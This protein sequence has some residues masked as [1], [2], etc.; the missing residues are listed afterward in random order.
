MRFKNIV[1]QNQADFNKCCRLKMPPSFILCIIAL[2]FS[3]L[4]AEKP[5]FRFTHLT[6]NDGLSQSNVTCI[7]QDSSGFMWFGTFNGLNRFDGY[8]FKTYHYSDNVDY[9][10]SHNF[11]SDLAVDKNGLIWIGTTDGLNRIDPLRDR[12]DSYNSKTDGPLNFPD[13]Q[14]ET[15]LIDSENR[16]WAGTRNAGLILHEEGKGFYPFENKLQSPTISLLFKDRDKNIWAVHDNGAVDQINTKTFNIQP[17][18]SEK[19]LTPHRISA[20]VQSSDG[21]I[22]IGTQGDGLY[23][24]HLSETGIRRLAHYNTRS[25]IF[26]LSSNIVI[27]LLVDREGMIWVGTEDQGIDILDPDKEL[28]YHYEHDPFNKYSLSHNSI[29]S[30][31]EDMAGNIWIGT[32]AHGISLLIDRN[33]L[34]T[35]YMH[36]EGDPQSLSHNMVNGFLETTYGEIWIATDGGGLNR[37]DR[38]HDVFTHFNKSNSRL[39]TDVIL[40]LYEDNRGL[41]WIG[42]W[43]E[44]L[45]CLDRDGQ[46]FTNY[47]E[48]SDGLASNRVLD[49]ENDGRGGLWLATFWRG[50]T[51]FNPDDGSVKIYNTENSG[52]SDNNVRVILRDNDGSLWIGTDVGLDRF[53]PETDT[54]VNYSHA[55]DVPN[56]LSK[57]FV[58]S[59][60]QMP[61][62]SVWAGTDAGLNRY[63]PITNTF[64]R[65]DKRDGLP[66]NEIKCILPGEDR[67]LWLSTNKGICQFDPTNKEIRLFDVS[68][69]LQGNEFN[70]R[71]GLK[72]ND[73]QILFG[74]NNGFNL[75]QPADIRQNTYIP[76]VVLTD[77]RLFNRSVRVGAADSILQ[78]NINYTDKITLAYDQDVFAFEFSA[79]NYISSRDN[80]YAYKL[81]G[82]E[83]EW[84]Q[85]GNSRTANYTNIDPGDYVF[86]VKA[87][88]NDGIW[89]ESG[90]SIRIRITPPFWKTWWA[91]LIE[92]LMIIGA[93]YFILNFFISRQKMRSDLRL[94]QLELEKMYELDQMKTRFFSNISHEFN[95]PM[96]LIL[97][98]LEKL[99]ASK[100]LDK[101]S[102]AGIGM[103]L[104][105][106]QRLHRMINQLKDVQKIETGDLSLQ[107]STGDIIAFLKETVNSFHEYAIDH[108]MSLTFSASADKEIAWF[109]TDK[110]DKIIYNLLSNA[111]KFTNDGGSIH[112]TAKIIDPKDHGTKDSNMLDVRNIEISVSDTGIGIPADKIN[113]ITRRFFRIEG[114]GVDVKEGSGIGLAFVNEL[115]KLYRGRIGVKSKV[116][117][118]SVFTV[119]IPLDEK[120]LEEQ[121]VVSKFIRTPIREKSSG[122][123]DIP[124]VNGKEE[125]VAALPGS[126]PL[127]MV[128][129]DDDEIR[130][131]ICESLSGG[132]QI[133]SAQDGVSGL[134]QAKKHV[135]DLIISD[136]KMPNMDGIELCNRLKASEKTSHIPVI[137]LTAYSSKQSKIEGLKTGADAY[138]AKPFNVD[139]LNAQI[140]N[141]LNSRKRLRE[142]FSTDFLVGPQSGSVKDIDERFLQRL[143][144]AIERNISDTDLNADTLGKKVG[145]SRTQLYRK[146]R[147]L[148]DQTVSEFIKGIRLKRAAQLLSEKRATITEIAYAVGFNDLTYFARCFRKQYHK[149]P[150]EYISPPK[151]K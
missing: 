38:Q 109:D 143:V 72:L 141:L 14:V 78:R 123:L 27:S 17:I 8:N 91:Y 104:R 45:Y 138:L 149:S 93:V 35:H 118:G 46:N 134:E 111:F 67:T 56:S 100:S 128:V 119:N 112:V 36:H 42:T 16:V 66:D 142:K 13:D 47:T 75:F 136:I 58:L 133:I 139:M 57:G 2:S 95:A 77:F 113:L 137:L 51:H 63:D 110:L 15:L 52:L 9:S 40:S 103:I 30:I 151:R 107:L 65:Y 96:T 146:I 31:F 34:F 49:I 81:E 79:L 59:L 92:S 54:F 4:M 101:Q 69:G 124:D 102:L 86:K 144:D 90:R 41:L 70:V 22:W 88:N 10:L 121:Q 87:S 12:I 7:T 129:E 19:G 114:D 71:S 131:Y 145:M 64:K 6:T 105:N 125:Y 150:S 62:A 148:T 82:F 37:W 76:P 83:D 98:P 29:W 122:I 73:G 39:E 53:D 25:G 117:K 24:M 43:A 28:L 115:I 55:D 85:V 26:Q 94:E 108:K 18:F 32:Y 84:N 5:V 147:G 21:D 106:A 60:A 1:S 140:I 126:K 11:I 48:I 74:G 20:I 127:I 120:Y 44:G 3:V 89:N 23:R 80:Q 99:S 116:G 33:T 68:D 61:D 97:S 135:P 132:Y 50:L 130:K